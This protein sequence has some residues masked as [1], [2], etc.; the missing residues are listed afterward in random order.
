MLRVIRSRA[1]LAAPYA[2]KAV[3]VMLA[4][5]DEML[6]MAP[7]PTVSTICRAASLLRLN[8]LV[9]LKWNARSRKPSLVSMNGRGMVPPA[10]LTRM[11]SRPCSAMV[12]LDE[13]AEG[14]GVGDVSRQGEGSPSPSPHL[15]GHLLEVRLGAGR[16]HDMRTGLGQ[17]DG[18]A[19]PDAEPRPGDDGDAVVDAEAIEDQP[20]LR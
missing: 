20:R 4:D 18:D 3:W 6:T 10:L 14:V 16:Q 11:S 7:W 15:L 17:S 12:A 8:A 1:A 19:P 13:G 2:T 9:T 5:R